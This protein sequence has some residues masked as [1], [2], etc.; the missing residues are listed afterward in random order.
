MNDFGHVRTAHNLITLFVAGGHDHL[1]LRVRLARRTTQILNILLWYPQ[2][3]LVWTATPADK[4]VRAVGDYMPGMAVSDDHMIAPYPMHPQLYS[5]YRE[6]PRLVAYR[7][8]QRS[9]PV[10]F[11]GARGEGYKAVT[12]MLPR[13]EI[14]Q[15]VTATERVF[16]S[17]RVDQARWLALLSSA[18]FFLAPPGVVIPFSHNLTEAMAVGTIPITNYA[19]WYT[20]PLVD[21][22]TCLTFSTLAELD[23]ALDRA[24]QMSPQA[25]ADM[26]Q[27]V[28]AYYEHVFTP[29][30]FVRRIMQNPASIIDVHFLD[31]L[32]PMVVEARAHE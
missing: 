17:P 10:L 30:A 28:I 20:P 2:V 13:H 22:E 29:A 27:R 21:G 11:A 9:I 23:A 26:R 8:S 3:R 6:Q 4:L 5:Q 32:K 25:I 19:H 7:R 14:I 15:H 18:N 1:I 16:V 31:E 12:G 24:H